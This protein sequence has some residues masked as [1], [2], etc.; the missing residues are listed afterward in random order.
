MVVSKA[1]GKGL[2]EEFNA[3]GGFEVENAL[4]DKVKVI[5][6]DEI[7]EGGLEGGGEQI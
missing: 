4:S 6:D 5:K 3:I 2:K 7:I 1:W